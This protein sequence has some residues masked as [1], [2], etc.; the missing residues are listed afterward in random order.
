MIVRRSKQPPILHRVPGEPAGDVRVD[1]VGRCAVLSRRVR[2]EP[3]GECSRHAGG[4]GR[5]QRLAHVGVAQRRLPPVLGHR[6]HRLP[7]LPGTYYLLV[8]FLAAGCWLLPEHRTRVMNT[9]VHV[10]LHYG[11][12]VGGGE[13]AVDV[14]S[15]HSQHL[16][17]V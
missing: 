1:A 6:A 5:L 13:L 7:A 14:Y 11:S 15:N 12:I 10:I 16:T 17:K 4:V 3:G 9:V 2:G 8:D